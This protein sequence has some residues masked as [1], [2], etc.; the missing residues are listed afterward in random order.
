MSGE[1]SAAEIEKEQEAKLMARFG[2]LKPKPKL[3]P[4]DHKYF[5]S[6]DW[7]LAKEGKKADAARTSQEQLPVKLE[8]TGPLA[9][10]S[11]A[12]D[13]PGQTPTPPE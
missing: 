8:P 3:L 10:R 2:G 11:T 5:D 9:R 4:K 13:K 6:A 1:K 7:A 12:L